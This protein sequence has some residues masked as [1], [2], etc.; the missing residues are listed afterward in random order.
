MPKA[1]TVK[2]DRRVQRTKQLLRDSLMALILERG[3]DATRVEDI[4]ERANLGRATFYL[5]YRDKEELLISSLEDIYD[6]LIKNIGPF[7]KAAPAGKDSLPGLIAFQHAADNRDL[8]R[9]MLSSHGGA[10]I[11]Q[12]IQEYLAGVVRQWIQAQS[13]QDKPFI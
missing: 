7:P 12:R 2:T 3:Y 10:A 6:G 5:H 13:D 4:T 11:R 8:Y 1:E 9:V